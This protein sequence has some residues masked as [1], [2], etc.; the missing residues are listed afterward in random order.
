ML[1]V[2]DNTDMRKY[3]AGYFKNDYRIIEAG[4]GKA[5]VEKAVEHIPDIIISDVMMPVMDGYGL[6]EKVKTDERTSHIPVILLTARAAKESR[7]EGL[8]TGADDFITK[9]FDRDEL[10]VRVKNLI[11]QQRKLSEYYRKEF[12]IIREDLKESA[13]T[14]DEKFL[15][16]V[17]TVVEKNLSNPEYGVEEFASDMALSRFQLHRKL[18]ALLNQSTTEFIRTIRLN[19]AIGLLKK[20]TGTISE[21]AYDAGFNNPT[22]FSISFKKQFGVSPSEY[23]NRLDHEDN[24]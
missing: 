24:S 18:S 9:P 21:I 8:G 10:Q 15:N 5:G 12:E 14:M 2:E 13:L 16:K 17:K 3:I 4:N 1:I 11:E 22:Y 19:F 7:L 23:L 20:R 6:C